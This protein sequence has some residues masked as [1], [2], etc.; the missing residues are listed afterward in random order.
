MELENIAKYK[1]RYPSLFEICDKYRPDADDVNRIIDYIFVAT[2]IAKDELRTE[3]VT[4]DMIYN[5][6]N[7]DLRKYCI[8]NKIDLTLI[9]NA[10]RVLVKSDDGL[11][12][13]LA[14]DIM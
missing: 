7:S 1:S 8:D 6:L 13:K 4:Y 9:S 10:C 2:E 12:R 11:V 14:I 3:V 5:A